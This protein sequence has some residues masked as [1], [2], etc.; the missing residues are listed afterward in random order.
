[1]KHDTLSFRKG[2][3]VS[4]GN[5]NSQA[6]VMVIVPG[7]REG[8]PD[9]RHRGADQ[10]L[11]VTEGTGCAV[12]NG[13]KIVLKAGSLI[14]IEAGDTHEITNTGRLLLKT[15]NVYVPPAYDQAGDELPRGKP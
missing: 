5:G 7:G 13:H 12:I 6:A 2:F 15:V 3:R 1:M 4:A 8:G 14:L 9:N 10:W 11:Y